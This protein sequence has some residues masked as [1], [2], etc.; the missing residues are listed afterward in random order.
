MNRAQ[1]RAGTVKQR[2]ERGHIIPAPPEPAWLHWYDTRQRRWFRHDGRVEAYIRSL[3]AGELDVSE[4]PT[5]DEK[6]C[7]TTECNAP[8]VEVTAGVIQE[9]EVVP[10]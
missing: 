3:A 1:R 6:P 9:V 10:E 2:I 7:T 4:P 5:S 8:I